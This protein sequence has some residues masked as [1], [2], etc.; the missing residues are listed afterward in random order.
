MLT[1]GARLKLRSIVVNWFWWV[2]CEGARPDSWR[3]KALIGT[4]R[5]WFDFT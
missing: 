1:P 2:I 5:P 3:A 4:I